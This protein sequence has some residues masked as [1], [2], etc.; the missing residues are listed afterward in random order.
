MLMGIFSV[1]RPRKEMPAFEP[2]LN[3]ALEQTR[4]RG[5][6]GLSLVPE[7]MFKK[8]LSLERRRSERSGR[9]F[10]LMLVH[11]HKY[12]NAAEADATLAGITKALS[13]TT[14]ETDLQGWYKQGRVIGTICTE[15]GP[16]SMT[17]ILNTLHSKVTSAMRHNLNREQMNMV[18]VSFHVF[19]DDGDIDNGGPAD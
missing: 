8:V 7:V 6:S 18:Q 11:T 4:S 10:V 12:F 9:R 1:R 5:A 14:R 16:G 19:P 17:A 2:A 3:S 15:I 13:L